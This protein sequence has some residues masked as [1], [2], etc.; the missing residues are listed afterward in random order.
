[1]VVV[2]WGETDSYFVGADGGGNCFYDFEGESA[3]VFDGSAIGIGALIDVVMEELLEEVP[4]CSGL[5]L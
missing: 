1:L 4:V 5:S 3:A 2:V